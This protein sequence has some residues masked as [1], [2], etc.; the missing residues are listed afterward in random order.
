[1]KIDTDSIIKEYEANSQV[2]KKLA[3]MVHYELSK[4]IKGIKT[5]SIS[6]RIKEVS[7]LLDKVRRK[8]IEKPFEQIH[9]LVGFRIV[10]LFLSD[11]EEIKK[12]IC[13]EFEVFEKDDKVNDIELNIFGYM[14]LH[15]KAK[16][17]SSFE[18]P[19]GEDIK[20]IPFEIQ[21]R[22]IAQDAWASISHYLDY[23]KESVIPNQLKRD[24]HALC[25]LFYVADTHFSFIRNKQLSGFITKTNGQWR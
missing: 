13:K 1:M 25:G 6:F 22:T 21:I 8:N 10:C 23:K 12:I 20:K 9:D 14:S 4:R 5:H 15:L 17:K 11:L 24:F 18:S 2:Y 16:L 7:S 19:Y 3:E